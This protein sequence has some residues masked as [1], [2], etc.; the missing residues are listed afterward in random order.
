MVCRRGSAKRA[1]DQLGEAPALIVLG[2]RVK[3]LA[4][5]DVEEKARRLCLIELLA[6]AFGGL[7]QVRQRRL[8]VAQQLEPAVLLLGPLEV[9]GAELPGVEERLDQRL[10]RIGAGLERQVAPLPAVL[11]NRR[12]GI[13]RAGILGPRLALERCEHAGL[14]QRRF[15]DAGIADQHR[16]PVGRAG[17][18]G[19]HLDGLGLAAEKIIAV[20]LLHRF[21]AAIGRGVTPQFAGPRAAAGGRVVQARDILLRRRIGADD[22]VQAA[23]EGQ[24]RHR[25]AFEQHHDQRK[26]G[27]RLHP[28]VE[29][30]VIF[31]HLPLPDA[32]F[33]DQ[34]NESVRVGDLLGELRR[35]RAAG[36]QM[37]RRE[38][39]ARCGIF[40]LDGGFEPFRQRLIG[41]VVAEKPALHSMHRG[42]N[43][44][45]SMPL[46]P[47]FRR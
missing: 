11:K 31:G 27:R 14:R 5:V 4:L 24:A 20:L 40:A 3:L 38:E 7:D 45:C 19:Q 21:E 9:G 15:A 22:E 39:D 12:P 34:Q 29:R 18:R 13:G 36:A 33:A 1:R 46:A 32:G 41:R 35:P 16:Q 37:C 2:A 26:V 6:A 28:A 8:A 44:V 43:S 17:K 30:L 10:E 23:D 25:L 42:F 47:P